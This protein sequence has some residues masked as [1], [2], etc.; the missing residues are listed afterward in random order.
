MFVLFGIRNEKHDM[1]CLI[2]LVKNICRFMYFNFVCMHLLSMEVH[3]LPSWRGQERASDFLE[4]DSKMV[5]SHQ[6]Y[7][8]Y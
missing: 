7:S 1:Q 8:G 3:H 2:L 5:A 6:E 4:S